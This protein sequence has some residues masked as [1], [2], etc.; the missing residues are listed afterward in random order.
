MAAAAM[1]MRQFDL[2]PLGGEA[3]ALGGWRLAAGVSGN[4]LLGAISTLGVGFYAPCM[5]M[6]SLL[7]M[8]P[9][10]AFPIMMGSSAFL[11]PVASLRFVWSRAYLAPVAAGLALG[12]LAGV[13]L[14]AF[15]VRSLSLTALRWLVI[16][17]VLYAA[18]LML[19]SALARRSGERTA[20]VAD[21]E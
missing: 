3:L 20:V 17:A 2:F 14:A 15:A 12:G 4:F 9:V 8:N 1:L 13:P 11:M 5:T 6:V 18:V 21:S 7:G 19:R 10:G 16:V